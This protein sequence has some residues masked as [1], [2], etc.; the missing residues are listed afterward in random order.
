LFVEADFM[1]SG[2]LSRTLDP[3]RS[4]WDMVFTANPNEALQWMSRQP[5]D[6][7]VAGQILSGMTGVG[8]LNYVTQR[9]PKVLQFIRCTP[10][11]RKEITGFVGAAPHHFSTELDAEGAHNVVKR[12]FLLDDWFTNP[13]IQAL[14]S[15]LHKLPA[16]PS[17]HTQ[18][19]NELQSP[20]ADFES[21]ARLI[22]QDPVMTAKML[23]L[24]N[25]AYFAL[26]REITEPIEAVMILGAE[27]TRSLIMLA[28][29]FSQFDKTQC[30]GFKLEELWRHSLAVGSFAHIICMMET[31]DTG[32]ADQAF[33]AGL[34]HDVG[35]LLLAGNLPDDYARVLDQAKRQ[36][37]SLRE[38]ELGVFGA[39][40]AELGACLLGNWGLPLGI[41]EAIGWHN[42]PIFS[43]DTG[44]SLLTAVHVANAID[45]EKAAEAADILVSMIDGAY[46]Q[47]LGLSGRR[48][49]WREMCESTPKPTDEVPTDD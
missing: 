45:H 27:R 44:F 18:I 39:T 15:K 35:K 9:N 5:C 19:L 28:K 24:V 16:L 12:A 33:T 20:E 36:K 22:A 47:R 31:R 32:L 21:V 49:R 25:S 11:E 2:Q 43:D 41:L 3:L 26:S 34:L 8:F 4:H 14:L 13:E 46:T 29:V 23:Q 30:E 7:V 17:L 1:A 40:H 42:R 48:N 38:A 10:E 37:L 6:A